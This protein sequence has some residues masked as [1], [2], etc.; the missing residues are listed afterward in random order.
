MRGGREE[1]KKERLAVQQGELESNIC[2]VKKG[3]A[4]TVRST[5]EQPSVY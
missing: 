1:K 3:A 4:D 5:N 2:L